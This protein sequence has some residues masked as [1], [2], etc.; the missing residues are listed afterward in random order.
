MML[1]LQ[2]S[3]LYLPLGGPTHMCDLGFRSRVE[4]WKSEQCV[5]SLLHYVR[6]A[7]QLQAAMTSGIMPF[8]SISIHFILKSEIPRPRALIPASLKRGDL[9]AKNI[10]QIHI[11][12]DFG[13]GCKHK[14]TWLWFNLY[15]CNCSNSDT[16]EM[17]FVKCRPLRI[18]CAVWK[19]KRT[20]KR[21]HSYKRWRHKQYKQ[22]GHAKTGGH[23]SLLSI[24][25]SEKMQEIKRA[26]LPETIAG[27][28][29]G[30]LSNM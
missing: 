19:R 9:R 29:A 3:L 30:L 24:S 23:K 20:V 22:Y 4:S 13:W 17:L 25:L 28:W 18:H 16:R 21:Q 15:S 10:E 7:P 2:E 27:R 11:D 14:T 5:D 6:K 26:Q 1:M 12:I 8:Q